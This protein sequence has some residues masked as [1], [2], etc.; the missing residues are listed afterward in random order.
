MPKNNGFH[1]W[2]SVPRN[3]RIS[4]AGEVHRSEI[5]EFTLSDPPLKNKFLRAGEVIAREMQNSTR[6]SDPPLKNSKF[7]RAEESTAQ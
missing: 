4:R 6:W 3:C 5:A 2:A 1:R 7:L